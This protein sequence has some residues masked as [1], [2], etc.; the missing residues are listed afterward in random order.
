MKSRKK[1]IIGIEI[2]KIDLIIIRGTF[3]IR[4]KTCEFKQF[5]KFIKFAFCLYR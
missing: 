1:I 2:I 5:L 3:E 4:K